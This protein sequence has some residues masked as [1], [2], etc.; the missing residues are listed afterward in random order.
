MG[1]VRW[2]GGALMA[3]GRGSQHRYAGS[4]RVG[5]ATILSGPVLWAVRRPAITVALNDSLLRPEFAPF[6]GH[7][8]RPGKRGYR[9]TGLPP[10]ERFGPALVP[11]TPHIRPI[12]MPA[13]RNISPIRDLRARAQIGPDMWK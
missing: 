10:G 2:D 7:I 4:R 13:T 5:P 9:K 8:E 6:G 11:V 3:G 1:R 12:V